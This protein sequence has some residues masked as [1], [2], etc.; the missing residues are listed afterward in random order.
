MKRTSRDGTTVTAYRREV[1]RAMVMTPG[2]IFTKSPR[3]PVIMP[4][5]GKNIA[6]MAEVAMKVG[7]KSSL[8]LAQA[9]SSLP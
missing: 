9:A 2:N 4:F 6:Q 5:I 7:R 8:A 1:M 3:Y